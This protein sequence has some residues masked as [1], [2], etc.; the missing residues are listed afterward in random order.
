MFGRIEFLCELHDGGQWPPE[1]LK[2]I[3]PLG[4]LEQVKDARDIDAP[5]KA[6]I[7]LTGD[8]EGA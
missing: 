4:L 7:V 3:P 1:L 5:V 8:L 6:N 2:K